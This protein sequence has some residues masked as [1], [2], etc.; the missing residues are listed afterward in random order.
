[1]QHTWNSQPLGH[2]L[3]GCSEDLVFRYQL[4][5]QSNV[6]SLCGAVELPQLQSYFCSS[7]THCVH[8]GFFKPANQKSVNSY[9]IIPPQYD[10]S[11]HI[12]GFLPKWCY[13]AQLCLVKAN[14][15]TGVVRHYPVVAGHR[16]QTPA[17]GTGTLWKR[18]GQTMIK[19]LLM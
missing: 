3:C 6:Q 9:G 17:C 15:V 10:Y 1:M 16:H 5:H 7:V 4:V 13:N 8:H 14:A 11:F 18:G 19:Y 2:R 12:Y